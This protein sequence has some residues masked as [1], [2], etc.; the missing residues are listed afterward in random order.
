MKQ[1]KH[2][3][4]LN[5]YKHEEWGTVMEAFFCCTALLYEKGDVPSEWK[6]RP[7]AG[8]NYI[9]KENSFHWFFCRLGAKKL[10]MY[11]N[12]LNRLSHCLELAGMSF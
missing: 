5:G 9:D 3:L 6:Y 12:Y 11:G 10:T 2:E 7:G 1:L 8:G 4:R